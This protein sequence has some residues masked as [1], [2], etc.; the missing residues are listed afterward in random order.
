MQKGSQ[1]IP[2]EIKSGSL[3]KTKHLTHLKRFMDHY[4]A[5][6]GF[7]INRGEQVQHIAPNIYQIPMAYL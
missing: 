4:A 5:P 3:V 6:I 2:I 7:V 1:L